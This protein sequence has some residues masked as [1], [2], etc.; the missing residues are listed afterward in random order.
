MT[1]KTGR[2]LGFRSGRAGV[3]E[4]AGRVSGLEFWIGLGPDLELKNEFVK[5]A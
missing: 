3:L 4:H 5:L 2:A 1:H